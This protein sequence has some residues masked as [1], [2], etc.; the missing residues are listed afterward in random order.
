MS[1]Q[2]IDG[3]AVAIELKQSLKIATEKHIATGKRK[4]GLAVVLLG[5]DPASKV[6]VGS[7]R[8]SCE[9]IGFNSVSHDLD[10]QTPEQELLALI[11]HLNNDDSIIET[12]NNK[13]CGNIYH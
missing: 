12:H 1:A 9:E 8:R 5:N 3:K 11:S 10:E 4:P 2:I 13:N 7:K 6:Y